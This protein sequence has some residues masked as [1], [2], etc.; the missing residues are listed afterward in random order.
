[1]AHGGEADGHG[2]STGIAP[3]A[4]NRPLPLGKATAW[5]VHIIAILAVLYTMK[6][7][8]DVLLPITLAVIFALLLGP[9]VNRLQ[10]WR[11][12]RSLAALVILAL[13]LGAFGGGVYMLSEPALEWLGKTPEAVA[14]LREEFHAVDSNSAEV[15]AASRSFDSLE[16]ALS[17]QPS[18]PQ[19]TQVVLT[20]PGWRSEVWETAK[21]FGVYG[22]LSVIMLFF[23]LTA[24]DALLK[25]FIHTLPSQRD[26]ATVIGV[27]T[28][29]Q[30]QMS[31]YLT[32]VT[33]V[34]FA[35]GLVT[36]CALWV[37]DFPDPALWGAMA[38]LLRYIPYLGVS[39]MIGLLAIISSVTYDTI[40]M[41]LAAPLGFALFT[42]IVGQFVDPLVHG[43]RF[44]LN[45]IVVF[46]WIFFWGW[47]WG[48]PGV[49]L[50]VPLLTLVQVVCQHSQ[51]LT[52]LAHIIGSE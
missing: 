6:V 15:D 28:A 21:N 52:P 14:N 26:K 23:L 19:I 37:A 18:N 49:L 39:I 50:A 42:A 13:S 45:P 44:S 5:A 22:T 43:L 40:A 7:A 29:A 1:M 31:R 3:Q 47:L 27:A 4:S 12:P 2:T 33:A 8:R 11:L 34:N 32:T 24:G 35:V 20:E 17:S 46:L 25:R 48:A 38:A 10:S 51:R 9:A 16:K 36:A 41:I 30:E